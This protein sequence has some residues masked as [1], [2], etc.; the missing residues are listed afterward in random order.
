MMFGPSEHGPTIELTNISCTQ[1]TDNLGHRL[2]AFVSLYLQLMKAE[3]WKQIILFLI[4]N[5]ECGNYYYVLV[6]VT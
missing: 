4:Y 3:S 6:L 1:H 5:E 2:N